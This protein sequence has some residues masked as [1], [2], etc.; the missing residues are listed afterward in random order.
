MGSA[1][2][3]TA[4]VDRVGTRSRALVLAGALV[5]AVAGV[6][7]VAVV[8]SGVGLVWVDGRWSG[9]FSLNG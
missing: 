9:W 4:A 6:V 3:T 7:G 5:G 8:A 2:A 1:K